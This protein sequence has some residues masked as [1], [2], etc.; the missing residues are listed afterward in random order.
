VQFDPQNILV[1]DFGQLGDVVLSLPA[2]RALR[3]RFPH[4]RITVAVGKPGA[5]I[6]K[7]SGYSDALL[8][9]DRVALRDGNRLVSIARIIKPWAGCAVVSLI[10]SI[11]TACPRQTYGLSFGC[12]LSPLLASPRRSLDYLSNFAQ[13]A[14][15]GKE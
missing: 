5:E 1:I 4:A 6:I 2:L 11:F 8:E 10:L 9:V 14:G 7:L 3:N 13:P 15:R 12:T